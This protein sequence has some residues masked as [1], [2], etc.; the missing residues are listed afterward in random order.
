M[1]DKPLTT[2]EQAE[3]FFKSM[4]C[5][6]FHMSREYPERYGEYKNL[7]ISKEI[8]QQWTID[9]FNRYYAKI[10]ETTNNEDLWNYH[11]RMYDLFVNVKT[12]KNL[13]KMRDITKDILPKVPNEHKVLVAETINGRTAK[14]ARSGLIFLSYDMNNKAIAKEFVDL[15]LQFSK[16]SENDFEDTTMEAL[17]G[18]I[19]IQFLGEAN[20]KSHHIKRCKKAVE[21]C[22]DIWK[23]LK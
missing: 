11:S 17:Y 6:S 18:V 1:F 3:E 12:E 13:I 5:S 23:E 14:E 16:Y 20:Y 8:E 4:G 21:K 9:E 7:K 2:L 19:P 15:S 10:M 22:N